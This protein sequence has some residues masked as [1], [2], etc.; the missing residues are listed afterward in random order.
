MKRVAI[1]VAL[2][3]IVFCGAVTAGTAGAATHRSTHHS[4]LIGKKAARKQ[5]LALIG[6]SKAASAAFGHEAEG[7]SDT[8]TDAEALSDAQPLIASIMKLNQGLQDDRWPSNAQAD[9]K[10]LIQADDPLIGDLRSLATLRRSDASAW[11]ATF[12]RDGAGLAVAAGSVRQDL[13]LPPAK[14]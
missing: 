1:G 7:W 13:G 2:L 8:T 11:V 3:T 5:Y 4:K 10:A 6:P 12:K 9:I 14:Q